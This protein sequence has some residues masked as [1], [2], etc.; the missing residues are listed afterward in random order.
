MNLTTL[1]LWYKWDIALLVIFFHNYLTFIS[2]EKSLSGIDI[3]GIMTSYNWKI[4]G[5]FLFDLQFDKL[6]FVSLFVY[7]GEWE[8]T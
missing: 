1:Q 5:V 4:K 7:L 2:I 3:K 6:V 8:R